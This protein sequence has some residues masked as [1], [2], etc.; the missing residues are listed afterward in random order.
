L[1]LQFILHRLFR[2]RIGPPLD[3][4]IMLNSETLRLAGLDDLWWGKPDLDAA[5]EDVPT[6]EEVVLLSHNPDF[7]EEHPDPRVGLAL[8]GH[9]HGGQVYLP[10][11]GA[12]W[13]PTRYGEKYLA[14]LVRGPASQVFVTRGLGE[15]GVPLRFNCP[16]EINL[17]TLASCL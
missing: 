9:T 14:G 15:A 13:A 17:L 7:A 8:S 16:P 6:G 3:E 10:L 12:P 11:L 1:L 5:L 2:R 4:C